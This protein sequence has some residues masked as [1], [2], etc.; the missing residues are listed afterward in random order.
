[1]R[2]LPLAAAALVCAGCATFTPAEDESLVEIQAFVD[3]VARAYQFQPVKVVAHDSDVSKSRTGIRQIDV[4]RSIL[5]APLPV[6]D[7]RVAR[8]LGFFVVQPPEPM[9]EP[10]EEA[11][12]RRAY[13]EANVAAVDILARVKGL[14]QAIA[15]KAVHE[16]LASLAQGVTEK[17]LGWA[18]RIPHPCEQLRALVL[19]FPQASLDSTP[20]CR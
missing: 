6:R 5:T 7:V 18:A 11:I 16:Y 10:Q 15:I 4:A 20:W 14:P 13:P 19:A 17:R 1:M 8:L 9:S 12:N 3:A 2:W